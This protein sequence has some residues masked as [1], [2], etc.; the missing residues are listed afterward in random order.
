MVMVETYDLRPVIP[1]VNERTRDG[2]PVRHGLR[3]WTFRGEVAVVDLTT[4]R[5]HR[6]HDSRHPRYG[7]SRWW[8]QVEHRDG[9]REWITGEKIRV[10]HP[11]TMRIA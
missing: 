8:F 2:L 6:V 3:V 9:R 1:T 11:L 7:C 5:P 10:R 4:A